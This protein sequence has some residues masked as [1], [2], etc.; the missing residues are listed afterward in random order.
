MTYSGSGTADAALQ[1]VTAT[2]ASPGPGCDAGDFAGFTSGNIVLIGR[3]GGTFKIKA[4][5]AQT[6]GATGAIIYNNADGP[7]NGTLG[8]RGG[9][10]PLGGPS[11]PGNK[12]LWGF[13]SRARV[14]SARAPRR[15][16]CAACASRSPTLSGAAR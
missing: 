13:C 15:V 3:G 14:R 16:H 10:P 6:A 2:G 4:Q 7:L 9:R 12:S 1:H 11:R 8:R 5:N